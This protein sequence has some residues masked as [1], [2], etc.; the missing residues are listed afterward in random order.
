VAGR[1]GAL[2]TQAH[3]SLLED[4]EVSW[5]EADVAVDAAL[6]GGAFGARMIGGGFGG[7]VLA[8]VP[9]AAAGAV[10][11][12]VTEA[13]AGRSWAEPGFLPADP[14]DGAR[15]LGLQ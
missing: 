7:S 13:F 11:A 6:A 1:L 10:R 3:R 5:P 2:L 12:E 15:R 4:F 9:E 14:S 8:L